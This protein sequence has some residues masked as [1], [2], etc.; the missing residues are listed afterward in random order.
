VRVLHVVPSMSGS[1]GGPVSV[2]V[3][4][5]RSLALQGVDSEIFTTNLGRSGDIAKT[6]AVETQSVPVGRFSRLWAGHSFST[7][8]ALAQAVQRCDV[9]HVH[10]LWH[11]PHYAAYQLARKLN[12]PLVVSP[13]GELD[14]WALRHKGWKKSVYMALMQ[15]RVL[16]RA[17][18]VH[19]LTG[20]EAQHVNRIA[21]NTPCEVVANGIDDSIYGQPSSIANTHGELSDKKVVLFLG[22]LHEKKGLDTLAEAVAKVRTRR[23]DV[24]LV[25]AG[26]S[27]DDYREKVRGFVDKA[28]I[29]EATVFSGHIEG[30]AKLDALAAAD[31]FVLPSRSE[32]FPMAVLESLAAGVPAVITPECNFPEMAEAGAGLQVAGTPS[33]IAG[34]IDRVLSDDQMQ[35]SMGE[36]G[37]TLVKE[38]FTWDSVA[39][40]MHAI[41]EDVSSN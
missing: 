6:E 12:R 24:R 28:G 32:G 29:G 10:E 21:P 9:V 33:A 17:S 2:L 5:I 19:A 39:T 8:E 37:M 30:Q 23:P 25:I 41:Y 26:D 18:A 35:K 3:G 14:P 22:R 34:A 40:K 1:W 15:K 27:L 13:H 20:E 16:R 38:R 11:H 7:S 4:L 36:S 31:V